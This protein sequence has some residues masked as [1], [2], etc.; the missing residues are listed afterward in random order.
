VLGGLVLFT[1]ALAAAGEPETLASFKAEGERL[2][3]A[4]AKAEAARGQIA[5]ATLAVD[6]ADRALK[7]A[8]D[9]AT[10]RGLEVI[11][12]AEKL[13]ARDK[14][15]GCAWG[16]ESRNIPYVDGCNA[17]MKVLKT[18]FAEL[19]KKGASIEE[20]VRTVDKERAKVTKRTEVLA[21]QEKDNKDDLAELKAEREDYYQRLH[22]FLFRSETYERLK[23]QAPGSQICASIGSL[24]GASQC[25]Q[26]LWDGAR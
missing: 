2:M 25:L 8:L 6:G 5:K 7:L 15:S 24:E 13:D 3:A 1:S 12:A 17:L 20:Y 14:Q 23:K 10:H 18:E 11:G 16:T 21:R 22:A 9:A 26:R 4:T 19:E